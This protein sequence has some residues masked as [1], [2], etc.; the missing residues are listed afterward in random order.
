MTGR[1][2][3]EKCLKFLAMWL[4]IFVYLRGF[5]VTTVAT[6]TAGLTAD[7][8][9]HS[10]KATHPK[11]REFHVEMSDNYGRFYTLASGTGSLYIQM[12]I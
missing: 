5:D 9:G 3:G 8:R 4:I 12:T 6:K 7:V 10:C 2:R 11:W 1:N